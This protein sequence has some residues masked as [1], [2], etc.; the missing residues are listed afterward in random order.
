MLI[1]G[2]K[3]QITSGKWEVQTLQLS[4]DKKRFYFTANIDHPGLTD[5]YS[6][7]VDGGTPTKITGYEGR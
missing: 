2:V 1:H 6:L 4:N 3:K 7:P 5:F